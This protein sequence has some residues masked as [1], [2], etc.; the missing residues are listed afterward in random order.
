MK[1]EINIENIP[2]VLKNYEQWV[3]WKLEKRDKKLTKIPY[4][5]NGKKAKSNDRST[6]NT[7]ENVLVKYKEEATPES[8][9]C[10]VVTTLFAASI[11][12]IV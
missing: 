6:W 8:D 3:L 9:L 2:A 4:Q 11:L 7:F 5:P 1:K 10:S 12:I